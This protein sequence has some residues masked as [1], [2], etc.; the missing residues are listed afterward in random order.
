VSPVLGKV[1]LVGGG[2]GDPGLITVRGKDCL[3]RAEAVVFDR[4]VNKALLDYAPQAEK[5]YVG[6]APGQAA[7]T[8][9]Q[10]NTK[11]IDLAQRYRFVVRLKGGDPFV[12]GRGGE[13][14]LA[15]VEHGVPFEV[16]PGVTAGIAVPAMVGIPVT[17]RSLAS[18]VTFISGHP[19]TTGET[20]T[21]EAVDLSRL[22][23]GQ[24][25]VLYMAVARLAEIT[26]ELIRHGHA[27]TTAVAA[28]EQGGLPAQ[29]LI[30]GTLK[31]I[32]ELCTAANLAPPAIIVIGP[33]VALS[34]LL[35]HPILANQ[36][37]GDQ[38]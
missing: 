13:E 22:P 23:I 15:L 11:L 2:P 33:T 7:C 24:T 18:C 31:N 30:Q 3:E 38:R 32:A 8:Q 37:R 16:V 21:V 17:H 9:A 10:I 6:K 25:L 12:F 26:A 28:I 20:K 1:Y 29:R 5:V 34:E 35:G 19:G 14:A 4:L 36:S 27:P